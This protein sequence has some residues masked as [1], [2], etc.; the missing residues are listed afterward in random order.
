MS[1]PLLVTLTAVNTLCWSNTRFRYV[2]C[3]VVTFSEVNLGSRMFSV[4]A[5]SKVKA[6]YLSVDNVVNYVEVIVIGCL[7]MVQ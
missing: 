2:Y 4:V 6:C 3:E 5:L 1:S 7:L